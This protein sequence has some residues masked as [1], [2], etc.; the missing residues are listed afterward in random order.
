MIGFGLAFFVLFRNDH[1][2]V[3]DLNSNAKQNLFSFDAK[4][5]KAEQQ[6]LMEPEM[7]NFLRDP[8]NA[9]NIAALEA[10]QAK[11]GKFHA[12]IYDSYQIPY[13]SWLNTL[14]QTWNIMLSDWEQDYFVYAGSSVLAIIL[15]GCL[16]FIIVIVLFNLLIAIMGDTYAKV[17]AREKSEFLKSRAEAIVGLEDLFE[18]RP[19]IFGVKWVHCL[20]P[21]G[22]VE[23]LPGNV[24]KAAHHAKR[25]EQKMEKL[26]ELLEASLMNEK[27][28]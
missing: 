22:T 23:G 4:P 19:R 9:T 20:L 15:F 21:D 7:I 17:T 28:L 1:N 13:S 24:A 18:S 5:A 25:Q 16:T 26:Q 11:S 10:I 27:M 14:F 8:K 6:M 12:Q 2:A 3:N